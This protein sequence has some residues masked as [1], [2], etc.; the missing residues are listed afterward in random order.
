M[1]P[2]I[3]L[4]GVEGELVRLRARAAGEVLDENNVVAVEVGMSDR[5]IDA[6][7]HRHARNEERLDTPGLESTQTG[8]VNTVQ[9]HAPSPR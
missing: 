6:A 8:D 4:T 1:T 7:V 9:G 2:N 5:R 3:R